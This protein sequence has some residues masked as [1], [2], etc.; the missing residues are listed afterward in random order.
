[1]IEIMKVSVSRRLRLITLTKAFITP[2][3]TKTSSDNS[4][5]SLPKIAADQP[6]SLERMSYFIRKLGFVKYLA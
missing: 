1:M 6:I 3:I 4:G 5:Y 2:D